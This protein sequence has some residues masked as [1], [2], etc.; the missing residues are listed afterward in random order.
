LIPP[1]PQNREIVSKIPLISS[2]VTLSLKITQNCA[3]SSKIAQKPGLKRFI[4]R[5]LSAIRSLRN[6]KNFDLLQH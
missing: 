3:K 5:Q 6:S 4:N 2:N 1:D